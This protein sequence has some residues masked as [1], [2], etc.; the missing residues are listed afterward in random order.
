M[1]QGLLKIYT[2]V[3]QCF[4]SDFAASIDFNPNIDWLAT[5]TAIIDILL[6]IHCAINLVFDHFP[7]MWALDEYCFDSIHNS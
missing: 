1:E 3:F 2:L 6:L 7:A 4:N 5:D